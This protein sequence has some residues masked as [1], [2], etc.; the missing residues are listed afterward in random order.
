MLHIQPVSCIVSLSRLR[1]DDRV[2]RW[3]LAE[4]AGVA[5]Y[6]EHIHAYGARGLIISRTE[7]AKGRLSYQSLPFGFLP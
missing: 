7:A 5:G 6:G 3:K 4:D 2:E 1:Q